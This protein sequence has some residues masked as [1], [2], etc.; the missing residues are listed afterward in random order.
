MPNSPNPI[1]PNGF[2]LPLRIRSTRNVRLPASVPAMSCV[3]GAG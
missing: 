2:D 1:V 3:V